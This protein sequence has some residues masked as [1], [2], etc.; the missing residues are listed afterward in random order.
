M[1][2]AQHRPFNRAVKRSRVATA[3]VVGDPLGVAA[4]RQL[5]RA[6]YRPDSLRWAMILLILISLSRIHNHL[7]IGQLRPALVLAA[8]CAGI[9]LANPGLT[10]S[11]RIVAFWPARV[12][13]AL[14]VV[15]C[16]SAPFGLS[17]GASAVFIVENYLK[18]IVLTFLT[19]AGIRHGRDLRAFVWAYVASCAIL[20]SFAIFIFDLESTSGGLQRLSNLYTFDANDIATILMSG[21]PLTFVV[22]QTSRGAG[23]FLAAATLIGIAVSM[24]RS[25]S[26]GGFLALLAVGLGLLFWL[27]GVS[28]VRRVAFVGTAAIGLSIAAPAGYWEQMNTLL[29]LKEDYNWDTYYGRR[30]TAERGVE[31]MLRYPLFGVGIG[32]FARADATISERARTFVDRPGHALRW[33]AAH[34]SYVEIGSEMGFTGLVL[35]LCLIFGGIGSMRRLRRRLPHAWQRGDPDERFIY[36]MTVCLPISIIGFAVAA[37]WVSFAY[38]DPIYILMAFVVG[39]H[40]T[41]DQKRQ[42]EQT[43][44][45]EPKARRHFATDDRFGRR[46]VSARPGAAAV[47]RR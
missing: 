26:R 14:A 3:S 43:F 25:G 30:Q 45:L 12:I 13:L 46:K 36:Y 28:A 21:L 6:P 11:R 35:W 9:A 4:P 2:S 10:N 41:V 32:N 20:A 7:G 19:I 22:Y 15:A 39:V 17:L 16:L 33:R 27:P 40:M 1:A 5:A 38:L 18:V 31:Y 44:A 42:N 34:N 29:N 47:G 37:F 8:V 24:A 23:R